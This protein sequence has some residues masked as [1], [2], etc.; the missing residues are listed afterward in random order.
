MRSDEALLLD[1]LIASRKIK[2]FVEGL[3]RQSF[4]TNFMAQSAVTHEIQIIGEAIKLLTPET[5]AKYSDIEWKKASGMRNRIVHKYFEV[6]L[7]IVWDTA[8]NDI[9]PL[10]EKLEAILPPSE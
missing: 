7:D 9:I 8:H 10:I 4:E 1:I 6:D 3:T 2:S 5:K